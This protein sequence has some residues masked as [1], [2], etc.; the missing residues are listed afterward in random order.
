MLKQI[1]LFVIIISIN[2]FAQDG[3]TV[4]DEQTDEPMLLGR[5]NREAFSDSSFSWWFNEEYEYYSIDDSVLVFLKD[6][7]E[8]VNVTVVMGTWCSDS[9]REVPHFYKIVDYLGFDESNIDLIC[10]DRAKVGV[11]DEVDGLNIKLV[12]TFIFY[13]DGE[14]LGRIVETPEGTLEKDISEIMK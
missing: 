10:V 3:I 14:E 6:R 2:L 9:R 11:A 4:I 13:K 1:S 5:H 8:N 7:M 12:P